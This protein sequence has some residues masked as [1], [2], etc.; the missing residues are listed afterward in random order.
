MKDEKIFREKLYHHTVP[1]R[2]GLWE[3]IEAQLPPKEDRRAF[4]L[5]WFTLF[6][7]TLLGGALMIGLFNTD[8]NG[9]SP[10]SKV[11]PSAQVTEANGLH[12]KESNSSVDEKA[13]PA[14]TNETSK[15]NLG[16]SG[17]VI[18]KDELL[19]DKT[20]Q[21]SGRKNN[22]QN[23]GNNQA[24]TQ[25]EGHNPFLN[26]EEVQTLLNKEEVPMDDVTP[27]IGFDNRNDINVSL[28]PLSAVE[29]SNVQTEAV[30]NSRFKPDPN[31]Y[32]FAGPGSK[33]A[34]T[35]D[36][37]GGP[38]FSP[39]TYEDNSSDSN[40][41]DAR[42]AT[43]SNQYAWSVG[44]R[45]NLQ[46]RSGFT[47]RI[48]FLYSQAGDIFDYTDSL[49]TQS[50]TRID[51]FF[52]ADGTF[53][54]AETSQV[55][56]LGTLIKKIHNTYR[57]YDIPLILGYEVPLGRST[58]MLNA[59]AIF[60]LT[61]SH[62]GQI[63]DPMLHPRSIT[64]GEPGSIDVYKTSLGLGIYLGAGMLFPLTDHLSGIVEPSFLYRLKP[65][66]LDNY[67]LSEHRHYAGLNVGIRYHFN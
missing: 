6:G 22:N 33:F 49:A 43:E 26:E 51:S 47:G 53:L 48:G 41:A 29:L 17:A 18:S 63:L 8:D 28:L 59:G 35:A 3:A 20:I 56:I 42:K 10:A 14:N 27:G 19:E 39:K 62:E 46:H 65:V 66:T 60:N 50:T 4:P 5:F 54:Y 37:L 67:P 7:A 52:A 23:R 45:L 32:K 25:S 2:D 40:Y 15:N 30:F 11:N 34:I 57:Y 16:T 13:T 1:V 9:L 58:L 24:I 55:L 61:S 12:S 64:E 38:G 36:L 31:C 21:T 44:A